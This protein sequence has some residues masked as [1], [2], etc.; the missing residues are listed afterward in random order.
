MTAC[1]LLVLGHLALTTKR[2]LVT[3]RGKARSDFESSESN[4]MLGLAFQGQGQLDMAFDK[5][6]KCPLD[7]ALMD[8][9]YNLALDF[10]RKRQFNKAEAVFRYM[11][12]YN[13]KFR[14]L[15]Q[16]STRAKQMSETVILGG[17]R[18]PHQ[19]E[20]ADARRRH[21]RKADARPLPGGEGARQGRDGRRLSRQ[22]SEDRPRG[23][24][25][26]HGAVAGVRGRRAGR[27]EG[28]L[29]PRGRDRRAPEPSR[30]SSRSSTPARSTISPTSRWSSSRARTSRRTPSPT[31]CCRCRR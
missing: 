3:E 29:L 21:G 14:D 25:Q 19:R 11:A 16:R 13:P 23:R 10:E 20:H 17:A 8:N 5:F 15:E 28:A 18:R 9:L 1:V 30:T 7:D 4:R 12:D 27:G 2:F 22:G 6:R 31:T 26:D 24:D